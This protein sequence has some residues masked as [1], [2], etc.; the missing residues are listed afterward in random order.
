MW[1]PVLGLAEPAVPFRGHVL[2][3]LGAFWVKYEVIHT[4]PD[5]GALTGTV[6]TK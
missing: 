6:F 4:P 3:P 1:T 2:L 5:L